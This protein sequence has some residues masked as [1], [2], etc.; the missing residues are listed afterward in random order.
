MTLKARRQ[1]IWLVY[2]RALHR[3]EPGHG[4]GSVRFGDSPEQVR[5]HLGFPDE[6]DTLDDLTMFLRYSALKLSLAFYAVDWPSTSKRL[7]HFMTRHPNTRLWRK[8]V[9]GRPENEVLEMFRE[10]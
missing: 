7:V 6:I 2:G 10:R 4:I 1:F 5:K 3:I 9:I 8:K